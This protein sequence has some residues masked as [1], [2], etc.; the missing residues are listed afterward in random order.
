MPKASTQTPITALKTLMAQ[1][2]TNPTR[3]SKDLKVSPTTIR[4]ILSGRIKVTVPMA[5]RLARYFGTTPEYWTGLQTSADLAAA[6]KDKELANVLKTIGRAKKSTPSAKAAKT[7]APKKTGRKPQ[8]P[9]VAKKPTAKAGR[10]PRVKK[11]KA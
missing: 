6:A 3:T 1:Y 7:P 5:L 10:K 11:I 8:K 9:A 2:D 4:Q